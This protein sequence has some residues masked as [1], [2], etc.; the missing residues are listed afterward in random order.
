[1][2]KF[3]CPHC[4]KKYED[5]DFEESVPDEL[6]CSECDNYFTVL[7]LPSD[8]KQDLPK[9]EIKEAVENALT[10]TRRYILGRPCF[11]LAGFA[12]GL[13]KKGYKIGHKAEDEQ[14]VVIQFLLVMAEKH[15]DAWKDELAPYLEEV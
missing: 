14:A 12:S 1:M 3:S 15:G 5:D 6:Q 4:G 13:R 11:T 10:E 9:D 8:E 2:S 7:G